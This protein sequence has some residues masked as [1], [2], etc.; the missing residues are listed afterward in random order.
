MGFKVNASSEVKAKF[1]FL[2]EAKI[3]GSFEASYKYIWSSKKGESNSTRRSIEATCCGGKKIVVQCT[4]YSST[5][6]VPYTATIEIA[7]VTREIPGKW[8]GVVGGGIHVETISEEECSF[9]GP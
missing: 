2:V 8:H 5:V 9:G 1:D 7:G 4:M 3:N 6:I